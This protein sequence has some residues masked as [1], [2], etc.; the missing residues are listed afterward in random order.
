MQ[1]EEVRQAN[2]SNQLQAIELR[3]QVPTSHAKALTKD[4][5]RSVVADAVDDDVLTA[6]LERRVFC[7]C[8]HF[9]LLAL[10]QSLQLS[11]R[12]RWGIVRH[13][14]IRVVPNRVFVVGP[15]EIVEATDAVVVD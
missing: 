11:S 3:K 2:Q 7:H 12:K 13:W 14:E 8:R 9:L 10:S 1:L 15:D 6:I 4:Y 5:V